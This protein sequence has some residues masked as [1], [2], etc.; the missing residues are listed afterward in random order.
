MALHRRVQST[1]PAVRVIALLQA[2]TGSPRRDEWFGGSTAPFTGSIADRSFAFQLRGSYWKGPSLAEFRG[3]IVT[4]EGGTTLDGS[5]GP[6]PRVVILAWLFVM[7]GA[8][9][10]LAALSSYLGVGGSDIGDIIF[11]I[12]V[13]SLS[14]LYLF[15]SR[16]QGKK[17]VATLEQTLGEAKERT[18]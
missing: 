7:I 2:K 18:A 9:I 13:C 15:L 5:V 1:L 8:Y 16:S 12:L 14:P 4:Q 11:G 17:L 10:V 6:T 3:V